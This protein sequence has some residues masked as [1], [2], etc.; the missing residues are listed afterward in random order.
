MWDQW[1]IGQKP[2]LGLSLLL[3]NRQT[4]VSF[5]KYLPREL[6]DGRQRN[7]TQSYTPKQFKSNNLQTQESAIKELRAS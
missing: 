1:H 5:T 3:P 2:T 6:K 7:H 4:E